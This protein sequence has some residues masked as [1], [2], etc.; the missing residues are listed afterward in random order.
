MDIQR[1]DS[2]TDPRFSQ[3]VLYQHGAFLAD[4]APWAF[5]VISG[6]EAVVSAGEIHEEILPE[7][8]EN[9]RFYAEHITTFYDEGG[10]CL[11]RLPPV[12]RQEVEIDSL[13][14][15][16]FSVDREKCAAVGHFIHSAADVV[17]PVTALEDGALC[18]LDGHTRL[19]EAWR[20]GIRTAMAVD[21]PDWQGLDDF[22]VEA[23]RRNIYHVRDMAL[24][25][26]REQ[27]EKWH[28]WCDAYFAAQAAAE[29]TDRRNDE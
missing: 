9:F 11:L 3:E 14:P 13:Q 24:Y 18:V 4:G 22:V 25:S 20:R 10:R 16:Q 27:K 6:H 7:V 2:Y 23:R 8:V 17:I 15:S 19:Y 5:R 28:D 21:V 29:P 26:S 1:I 12:E